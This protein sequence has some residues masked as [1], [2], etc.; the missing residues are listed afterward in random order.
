MI[1]QGL[2]NHHS[3][4]QKYTFLLK[5]PPAFSGNSNPEI[6]LSLPDQFF[7]INNQ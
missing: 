5:S 2:L 6:Q 4:E 3:D 1:P 7:M